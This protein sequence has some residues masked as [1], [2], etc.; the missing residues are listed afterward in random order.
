MITTDITLSS[1]VYW[2]LMSLGDGDISKGIEIH[3]NS[4][5]YSKPIT[6]N[7][8]MEE[9]MEVASSFINNNLERC[10]SHDVLFKDIYSDYL[11]FANHDNIL[12]K[13]TFKR[14]LVNIG[15]KVDNGENNKVTVYN[16]K[17]NWL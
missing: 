1:K 3:F 2:K 7:K 17:S 9:S 11:E 13:I 16:V 4:N 14:L 6:K 5:L 12:G 8:I 15:F 10:E